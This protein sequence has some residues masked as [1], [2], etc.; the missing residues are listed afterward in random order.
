MNIFQYWKKISKLFKIK[1]MHKDCE[2]ILQNQKLT[3][4]LKQRLL[5]NK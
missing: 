3:S 2:T 4:K 5:D 1:N